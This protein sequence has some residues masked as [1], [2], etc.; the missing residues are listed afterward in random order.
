MRIKRSKYFGSK[1][2][3]L[4]AEPVLAEPREFAVSPKQW[5]AFLEVLERPTQIKSDLLSLFSKT[6]TQSPKSGN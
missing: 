6:P 4:L 5:Q 2:I 1:R 3:D